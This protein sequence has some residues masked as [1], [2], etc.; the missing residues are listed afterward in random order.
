MSHNRNLRHDTYRLTATTHH[1]STGLLTKLN[2]ITPGKT[3]KNRIAVPKFENQARHFYTA[4]QILFTEIALE[5]TCKA[6][7]VT[8]FILCH[9]MNSVMNSIK[10]CLFSI[11]SNTHLV[12]ICT[13]FQPSCASP[14]WSW[15]PTR[16]HQAT[17]QTWQHVQ[18][19]P[20]H[21]A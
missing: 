4:G 18:P 11:G 9:F 14:G 10:I 8:S 5:Q 15:Y 12:S 1:P 7:T 20:K 2:H 6:T 19:L 13:G 17:L 3:L 16:S 21:N